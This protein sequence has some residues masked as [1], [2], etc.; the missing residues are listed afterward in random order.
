MASPT[1]NGQ[2]QGHPRLDVQRVWDVISQVQIC[3]L[4][5]QFSTGLR[6]RPVEARLRGDGYIYF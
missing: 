6:A 3:M 4:G 2:A 1:K 5:T